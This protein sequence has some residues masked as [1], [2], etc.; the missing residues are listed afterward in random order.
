MVC[1][2]VSGEDPAEAGA[3]RA[4]F[5]PLLASYPPVEEEQ[6]GEHGLVDV[7]VADALVDQ[8]AG[9]PQHGLQRIL[10]HYAVELVSVEVLED[11]L[12]LQLPKVA[13][14]GAARVFPAAVL[15]EA[16]PAGQVQAAVAAVETDR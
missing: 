12:L 16:A 11:E 8:V 15:L 1:P 9:V 13:H 14:G 2:L 6:N 4:V 3:S 5:P 10:P 7:A